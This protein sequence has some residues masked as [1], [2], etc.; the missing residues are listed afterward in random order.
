MKELN[1]KTYDYVLVGG[2][3]GAGFATLG[4]REQDK[5]GS[6]LIISN[7]THVPYERPALT[8]KLWIDDEFKEDDTKIG[9]EEENVEIVFEREVTKISPE[10]KTVTLENGDVVDYGQLLLSTGGEPRSI[11]GPEDE[12]VFTFRE[13]DDYRKLRERSGENQEVIIVGGGYIGSELAASLSQNNTKVTIVFP[14]NHLGEEMFPKELLEEYNQL[15]KDHGV[16]LIN[17][18][19]AKSYRREGEQVVLTLDDDSEVKG[20]TIVIG[21]GVSPRTQLAEE[22]G[23]EMADEG[24]VVNE[25]L[26]TSDKNIWAAADIATYPDAIF[27]RQRLEHVDH[28]RH[29]GRQ[30]GKNMAGAKE[31]YTH[32]PYLYSML[33]SLNWEAVGTLDPSLDTLFDHR[34]DGEIVFYLDEDKLKGILLWNVEVDLDDVR[35]LIDQPPANKEDLIGALKE[36][37]EE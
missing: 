21:L 19:E 34:E 28:A 33:Y 30:V 9:A 12:A 15:F 24:V 6:I 25:W 14:Q 11:D 10:D 13:L 18:R 37:K 5:D 16:E 36:Q 17:G 35:E 23:L 4:I 20:D 31:A 7:E 26:Q 3:M 32:T 22:S 1:N 27:G 29:S 2:G 8:K